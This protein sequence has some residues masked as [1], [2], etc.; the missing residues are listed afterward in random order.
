DEVEVVADEITDEVDEIDSLSQLSQPTIDEENAKLDLPKA[1][2]GELSV[3]GSNGLPVI[4]LDGNVTSPLIDT[5]V[6]VT[7]E[8]TKDNGNDETKEFLVPVKGIYSDDGVNEKPEV[9]PALQE[10]YGLEGSMTI[11]SSTSLVVQNTAFEKAAKIFQEDL[12]D[13]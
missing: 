4:D 1:K 3:V 6:K 12:V 10:W 9:I 2:S 8:L 7:L 5:E 13:S 11:N